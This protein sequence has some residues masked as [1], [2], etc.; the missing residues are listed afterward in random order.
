METEGGNPP[1][2]LISSEYMS[3]VAGGKHF[4]NKSS[5]GIP[6]PLEELVSLRHTLDPSL[7]SAFGPFQSEEE[8]R[9]K[10]QIAINLAFP[11]KLTNFTDG[12]HGK[13]ARGAQRAMKCTFEGCP[14]RVRYELVMIRPNEYGWYMERAAME[15]SD[16]P[17]ATSRAEILAISLNRYIP[18]E[19]IAFG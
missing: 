9:R 16:H 5:M 8:A 10:L 12:T 1:T 19:L 3:S 6:R 15:H 7:S 14:F 13:K 18:D 4:P 17:M 11:I 2:A